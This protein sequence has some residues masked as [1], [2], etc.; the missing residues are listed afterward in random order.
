VRTKLLEN[1]KVNINK[2]K[3]F[4]LISPVVAVDYMENVIRETY[5]DYGVECRIGVELGATMI[6]SGEA[7]D[8]DSHALEYTRKRI[9]R[10]VAEEVYGDVRKQLI[11]IILLL[12]REGVNYNSEPMEKLER[13]IEMIQYD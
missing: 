10:M 8:N 2:E 1:I 13:L 5:M 6:I 3:R 7:I 4:A 9:G 12:Q 11:E